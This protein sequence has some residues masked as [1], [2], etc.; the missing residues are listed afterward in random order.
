MVKTYFCSTY[1]LKSELNKSGLNK[2]SWVAVFLCFA[3]GAISFFAYSDSSQPDGQSPADS[4]LKDISIYYHFFP[5]VAYVGDLNSPDPNLIAQKIDRAQGLWAW[6]LD[7][8]SPNTTF[9]VSD[10]APVDTFCVQKTREACWEYCRAGVGH[11][12]LDLYCVFEACT[13]Y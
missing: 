5:P 2:I 8:S 7:E 6:V 3:L 13:Y 1:G 11:G 10:K 4:C 9:A 12:P